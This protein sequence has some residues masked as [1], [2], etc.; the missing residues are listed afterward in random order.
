MVGHRA[1]ILRFLPKGGVVC[2]IGVAYG[3]FSAEIISACRPSHFI[4]I[5]LFNIEQ[6]PSMWGFDRLQ[7]GS[8][9]D[10]YRTRFQSGIE[11]QKITVMVG[12]STD[13]LAQIPDESVNVFYVDAWHSYE[14]V[15][16]ELTLIS[17]KITKD[18]WIILNDYVLYDVVANVTY[19]VIPAANEFMIREGWEMRFFALHPWMYCDVAI[20]RRPMARP[21]RRFFAKPHSPARPARG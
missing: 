1:E 7:G 19:G 18:G 21:R 6:Y 15:S 17:Q 11:R 14:A 5:D 12:N 13:M 3:D 16:A 9:L 8:H 4:A 2:E 20:R 10:F